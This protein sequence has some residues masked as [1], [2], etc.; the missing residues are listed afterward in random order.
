MSKSLT[1]PA[2]LGRD[3]AAEDGAGPS[4]QLRDGRRWRC[5]RWATRL[6]RVRCAVPAA[7]LNGRREPVFQMEQEETQREGFSLK[8]SGLS[9]ERGSLPWT[10]KIRVP[11]T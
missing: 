7:H 11:R 3:K 10:L 9:D 6:L 2:G 5:S 1:L 8:C 4:G